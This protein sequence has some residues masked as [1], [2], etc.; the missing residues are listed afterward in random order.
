MPRRIQETKAGRTMRWAA[1]VVVPPL[2]AFGVQS[3]L[4]AD[5]TRW[6]LFNA[7][8]VVSA[9]LGGLKAGVASTFVSLA[10]VW[11]F[12]VPAPQTVG[13]TDPRYYLAAAV[14]ATTGIAISLI[15]ERLIRARVALAHALEET[16]QS[17]EA[18]NQAVSQKHIFAALANNSLDFIG[19][20][21]PEGKPIYLNPAG[22]RMVDLPSDVAIENTQIADYYPPE[23]RG[24]AA[25]V[26]VREMTEH[27]SWAGETSFRNWRTGAAIPVWDTHFMITDPETRR[28]LGMGTITRDM[29]GLKRNS[30]QLAAANEQLLAAAR[31]LEEAQRLAHIGSWSWDL[32]QDRGRWSAELYRIHGRD[33]SLPVPGPIEIESL[34][35]PESA[36]ALH[37]AIQLLTRDGLPFELELETVLS[38]GSHRWIAARGEAV[39]GPSGRIER[40]R[41]TAQEITQLKMLERMKE[42][43]TSVVAHDLREPIHVIA[44]SAE[45]LPEFHRAEIS[46]AEQ[47]SVGHIRSAAAS[48]AKMVDNL[49]DVSR[50]EGQRLALARTWADPADLVRQTMTRFPILA[51]QQR[52]DISAEPLLPPVFVDRDR[53]EQVLSNLVT[54]A[55]VH[56]KTDGRIGVAAARS[57]EEIVFSVTNEGLGIPA[58]ELPR[59][60]TRYR[61]GRTAHGGAPGLGLGLYLAKGLV[62]AHGGRIWAESV[63]GQKTTFS[64]ALPAKSE[65]KAAA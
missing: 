60:F 2:V 24:F 38:D 3:I 63:P 25:D 29:S 45:M 61:R 30:D 9:W 31:D 53:F 18:L 58:D 47:A 37:A 51:E 40:I 10:L 43:W 42:E 62:E 6:L 64:F 22:R 8:V 55:M 16:Q 12:F 21:D 14:F 11:W 52:I 23:T 19:I 41:G 4:L 54:N 57:G 26:I 7:A 20:A 36:A 13:T 65:V 27:G 32:G 59:L 33:P 34:F 15:H 17:N 50:L 39:R 48:L 49:I 35:T 5:V 56:G 28:V 46:K 1:A 44:M